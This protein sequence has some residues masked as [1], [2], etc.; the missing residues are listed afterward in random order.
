[1]MTESGRYRILFVEDDSTIRLVMA[2]GLCDAGFE[3][4]EAWTGDQALDLL[5]SG[6]HF[7]VLFTDVRMPGSLDGLDVAMHIRRQYPTIPVL[8]ASAFSKELRPRLGT[9]KPPIA[10]ISKPY[11]LDKVVEELNRLIDGASF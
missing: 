5:Q 4:I 1:M 7:D 3:V 11:R 6:S 8:V 10:F 2:E 9:L